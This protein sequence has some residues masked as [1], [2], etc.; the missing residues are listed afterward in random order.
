MTV[1]P[2]PT[3]KISQAADAIRRVMKQEQC[4]IYDGFLY[5]LAP[6]SKFTFIY[7]STIKDY[8]LS[9]LGNPEMREI[10][11][12]FITQLTSLLSEPACRLIEPIRMNFNLI[13][14]LPSGMCFNIC[15]KR[16]EDYSNKQNFG[17]PRAFVKYDCTKEDN[18][19]PD[20]FVECKYCSF[21]P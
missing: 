17:S 11:L 10:L 6:G 9:L 3:S 18:P 12:P 19:Y 14:V 15:Q 7:G 2:K 16:F 1:P 5:T 21:I 4:G 13:E 8:L 20:K